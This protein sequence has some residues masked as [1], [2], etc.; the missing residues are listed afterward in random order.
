M[1][2]CVFFF[3]RNSNSNF[4]LTQ[5]E[6]SEIKKKETYQKSGWGQQTRSAASRWTY[7]RSYFTEVWSVLCD[8]RLVL[9][10]KVCI[11]SDNQRCRLSSPGHALRIAY[12]WSLGPPTDSCTD[13]NACKRRGRGFSL[14]LSLFLSMYTI[15]ATDC[16]STWC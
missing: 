12:G 5:K 2:T 10:G 7:S 14:T 1:F 6:V 15:K 9:K 8:R 16:C 11:C 4:L 3:N 13:T